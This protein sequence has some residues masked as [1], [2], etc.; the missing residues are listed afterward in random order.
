MNLPLRPEIEAAFAAALEIP[1]TDQDA[2][3]AREYPCDVE[4][5]AEVQS[6]LR[7]WWA[8]GGF[9][10]PGPC[11]RAPRLAAAEVPARLPNAIGHYRLIRL[12]GEGGMGAVYEAEQE[13]PRRTVALKVI[14]VGFASPETLR[15]FEQEAQALGRLQHQGIA[16]IYEAGTADNGFGTQ[17]YFAME[18]IQGESLLRYA[19]AHRATVSERLELLA[20]ICESVHHAHQRGIIHRDLKPGNILVDESGQPKILDF[21]V[22][23]ITDADIYAT[24]RTDAGHLVGTL[25]YMSP[26]Q[27]LGDPLE[28]DTRSDVYALGVI[29]FQLLAGRLPYNLSPQPHEAVRT[30]RDQDPTPLSAINRAYRGDIETIAGKAL[31]KDKARRYSS[32]ADLAADIRR[33]LNDEPIIARRP[34]ASY[35]V[36]KFVRRRR[37]LVAGAAAVFLVLIAGI[38][39]STWEATLARHAESAALTQA[40]MAKAINDFLENDLLTQASAIAQ[41]GPGTRPDPDLKVRTVLDRAA[42]H[43]TGKFEKQPLVEASIRQT[44]GDAYGDLGLYGDAQRQIERTLRLRQII[45]G[46]EHRDTLH[47]MNALAELYQAQGNYTDAEA[48]YTKVLEGRRRVLG[49]EHPD[50]LDTIHG[51]AVLYRNQGRYKQAEPLLAQALELQRRVLGEQHPSTLISMNSLAVLYRKQGK[52]AQA[53]PLYSKALEIQR[54]V[55]GNEHPDTLISMNNLAVLY[56]LQRKYA[57]AEPL[58]TTVLEVRRRVLGE[59]HPSALISMH[60]LALLYVDQGKYSQAD[61]LF[62]KVLEVRRRVLG[63]M[64]P[65]TLDSMND[66]AV[67]YRTQ[68]KYGQALP[69][70]NEVLDM[71]RHV[72]GEEHPDTLETICNLARLYV[73]QGKYAQAEP[74]FVKVL[75]IRRRV[76]G[77]RHPDTTNVSVELAQLYQDWRR[78]QRGTLRRQKLEALGSTVHPE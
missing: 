73:K 19:E 49:E 64:H 20:K 43:I 38:I 1:E 28:L 23:R 77:E 50:T 41:A 40:A 3:L 32:A 24:R 52:Y 12:I 18:F 53:E 67:L 2:F 15:R 48:L 65:N 63:K 39:A 44:I 4:L 72:L 45:L 33:Y 76:L 70:F 75:D 21:G 26:E 55:L 37:A 66:L 8:A 9:L 71:R 74:L 35:Q 5:R 60:N 6:M 46:G 27:V 54:R 30:I 42:A 36:A 11:Q 16:R 51:L 13:Q 62:A 68:G 17:P 22:A 47:T 69:L 14:K 31:A 59:E 29:L 56:K 25:A 10:E 78:P 58:Y 57:Q 34:T 7:T 61:Q